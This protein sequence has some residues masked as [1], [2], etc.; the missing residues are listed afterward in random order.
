MYIGL[1]MTEQQQLKKWRSCGYTKPTTGGSS[2]THCQFPDRTGKSA[3]MMGS[4]S[5]TGFC[6]ARELPRLV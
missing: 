4:L 3:P 6:H 5:F 2:A 1:S